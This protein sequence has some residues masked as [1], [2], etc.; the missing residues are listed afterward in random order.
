MYIGRKIYYE[1]LTGNVIVDTGERCGNVVET[2]TEQDFA[3]YTSLQ[4]YVPEQVGMIQLEY[5]QYREEFMTCTGYRVDVETLTIEFDFTQEIIDEQQ[6]QFSIEERL[7]L[8]EF[9]LDDMIL[10]GG[11]F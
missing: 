9:A 7:Q 2:T 1:K 6:H 4:R 11:T 8:L 5:G 3:M 10:N